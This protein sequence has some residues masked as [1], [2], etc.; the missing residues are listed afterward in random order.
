MGGRGGTDRTTGVV[1][2]RQETQGPSHAI[3]A[4][5]VRGSL[6]FAH[7]FGDATL[8]RD[9]TRASDKGRSAID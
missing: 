7:T 5:K 2:F 8:G 3:N 6:G 1:L 4:P 9:F